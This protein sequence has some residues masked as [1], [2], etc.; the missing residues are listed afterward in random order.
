MKI[1]RVAGALGAEIQDVDLSA[2]LSDNLIGAIRSAFAEHQVI[3]FRDQTLTAEQQLAF[4][5]A[6]GPGTDLER[7]SRR[8]RLIARSWP[9]RRTRFSCSTS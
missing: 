1:Q 6:Y 9:T 8:S 2:E 4:V 5:E 7:R 3:F